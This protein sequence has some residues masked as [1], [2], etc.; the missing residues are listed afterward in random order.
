[1]FVIFN[2]NWEGCGNFQH[3][4]FKEIGMLKEAIKETILE[5]EIPTNIKHTI[6]YVKSQKNRLKA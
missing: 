5:G 4:T 1:M 6:F 2:L 3:K